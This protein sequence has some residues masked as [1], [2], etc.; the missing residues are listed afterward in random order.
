MDKPT[1]VRTMTVVRRATILLTAALVAL[2]TATAAQAANPVIAA[3]KRTAD[4]RSSVFDMQMEVA[5]AGTHFGVAA[6]GATRG[7][8]SAKMTMRTSGAGQSAS[9]DMV[10]L[11]EGGRLVMYMRSPTFSA[12]RPE[13][14]RRAQR[15][16]SAAAMSRSLR[17]RS[18]SGTD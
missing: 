14:R 16:S 4:A 5:A 11:R 3:A 8:D 7:Q 18:F 1:C 6:S 9:I 17:A 13:C 2:L 10:M 12:S 15:S